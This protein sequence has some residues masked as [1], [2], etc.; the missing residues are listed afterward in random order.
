MKIDV[1]KELHYGLRNPDY[2]LGLKIKLAM[3]P[4]T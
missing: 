4:T 2:N 3:E 1:N